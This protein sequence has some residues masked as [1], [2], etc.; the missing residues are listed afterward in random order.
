MKSLDHYFQNCLYFSAGALARAMNE[1]AEE[2]FKPLGLA[3]SHAFLLM[4]ALER[5]GVTQKEAATVLH[6]APSTVSRLVDALVRKDLLRREE[7]AR[8]R[9][10]YPTDAAKDLAPAIEAAWKRIHTHYS[11]ALGQEAGDALCK[12]IFDAASALQRKA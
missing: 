6:L 12:T 5:P 11:E 1:V 8:A 3:P 9:P 4:L 2:K 10:I 7:G